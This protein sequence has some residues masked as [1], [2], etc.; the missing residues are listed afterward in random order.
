MSPTSTSVVHV[1]IDPNCLI[2]VDYSKEVIAVQ[3]AR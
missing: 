2:V 3:V 1:Q